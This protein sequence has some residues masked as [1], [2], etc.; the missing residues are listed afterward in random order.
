[1]SNKPGLFEDEFQLNI[2][3]E[4]I[5]KMDLDHRKEFMKTKRS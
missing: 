3:T 2:H 1:M 4:Y 5:C